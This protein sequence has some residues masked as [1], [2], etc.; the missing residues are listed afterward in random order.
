MGFLERRLKAAN[1]YASNPSTRDREKQAKKQ[2]KAD[3]QAAR[4]H[5]NHQAELRRGTNA[6]WPW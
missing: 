2:A 6:R 3:K 1:P 5:A 4:R